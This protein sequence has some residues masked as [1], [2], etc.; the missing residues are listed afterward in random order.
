MIVVRPP[1]SPR[2]TAYPNALSFSTA[3]GASGTTTAVNMPSGIQAGDRLMMFVNSWGTGF[4]GGGSGF[5]ELAR[6]D[7]PDYAG[8]TCWTKVATASEPTS[9]VLSGFASGDPRTILVVRM[10]PSTPHAVSEYKQPGTV[11]PHYSPNLLVLKPNCY[12]FRAVGSQMYDTS[13]TVYTWDTTRLS[14]LSRQSENS[15]TQYYSNLAVGVQINIEAQE[16][17]SYVHNPSN[18][19]ACY[20]YGAISVALV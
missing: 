1:S 3:A 8:V 7:D 9:M 18:P 12:H 14:Y 17:P 19:S 4:S 11:T 6:A 20:G 16:M 15:G 5:T 13:P 2:S 10:Q